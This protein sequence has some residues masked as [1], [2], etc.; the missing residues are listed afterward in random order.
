MECLLHTKDCSKYL[1]IVMPLN[2]TIDGIIINSLFQM[3]EMRQE[4]AKFAQYHRAMQ[5][6]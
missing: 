5:G 3:R 6:I 1:K 2:L 4:Y